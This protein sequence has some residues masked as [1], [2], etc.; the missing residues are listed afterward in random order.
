VVNLA[1]AEGHPAEV[2]DM[3]FA[4][5]ALACE[6]LVTGP[7]LAPGVHPVPAEIDREVARIK[8]ASLGVAID[9]PTPE[10]DRYRRGWAG[11]VAPDE[12]P[13]VK[14]GSG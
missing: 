1:A 12:T 10:Q 14:G 13:C 4:L 11:M 9:V 2:M 6:R 7:R 5:Q 3:S 8:L